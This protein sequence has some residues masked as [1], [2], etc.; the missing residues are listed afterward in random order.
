MTAT[1][2]TRWAEAAQLELYQK[3]GPARR[4]LIAVELSEAV[5]DTTLAGIRRRHPEF[6]EGE[7]ARSFLA[8]V[9]GNGSLR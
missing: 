1:D 4:A 9:Y 6:S 5:R 2:T 3:A 7:I 8:L